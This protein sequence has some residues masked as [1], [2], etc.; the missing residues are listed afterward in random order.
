M[1]RFVDLKL[2]LRRADIQVI[3]RVETTEMKFVDLK[4]RREDSHDVFAENWARQKTALYLK[5]NAELAD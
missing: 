1:R 2:K 4:L 3:L 5:L